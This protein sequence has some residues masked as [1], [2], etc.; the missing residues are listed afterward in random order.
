MMSHAARMLA[1]RSTPH[2]CLLMLN[3][4]VTFSLAMIPVPEQRLTIMEWLY[5][6]A[7][8]MNHL[9]EFFAQCMCTRRRRL[10]FARVPEG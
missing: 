7:G 8:R 5:I 10:A 9:L 3:V 2:G 1:A 6:L 4:S